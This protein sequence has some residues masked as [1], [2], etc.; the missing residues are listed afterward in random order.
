VKRYMANIP[1]DRTD[2]VTAITVEVVLAE[3]FDKEHAKNQRLRE[4]LQEWVDDEPSPLRDGH[5]CE[6]EMCMKTRAELKD[7]P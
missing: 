2:D 5:K 7:T 3:D 1:V 6:C 4:L